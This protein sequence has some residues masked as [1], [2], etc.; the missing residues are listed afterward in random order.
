MDWPI[1]P[2]T[3]PVKIGTN[4]LREEVLALEDDGF[5][6]QQREDLSPR[7]MLSTIATL[8]IP[9][10]HFCVPSNPDTH[11]T[12]RWFRCG[13]NGITLKTFYS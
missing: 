12:T 13:A 4:L 2:N 11:P 7:H 10:L 8:P 3:W 6:L 5:Q 9:W 1:V